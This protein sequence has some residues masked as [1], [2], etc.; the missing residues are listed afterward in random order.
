M[1][2]KFTLFLLFLLWFSA[3]RVSAQCPTAPPDVTIACGSSHLLNAQS[4]NVAYNVTAT[5]C[6]PVAITGTN[7]FPT[8][9]DDCVTGQ[10]PIGFNFDFYGNNYTTAVI[11]SNGLLG[12][13]AFTYTG[14][15]PFPIPAAGTPNNYIAGFHAD[16]DIRFGGTITYQTVGTAPNRRFVVSYNNVVPYSFGTGAGIGTASFQ[17]ILNENGSF[18]VVVSQLSANWNATTSGAL[19]TSGAENNDGTL[20][21]P[22]PGRNNTDWPGIVPA[23]QDCH[24]FSRI[25]CS[26]VRWEVAGVSVSTSSSY[27][28]SPAATTTYTAVWNCIG[29]GAPP[30][31]TDNVTVTV[32]PNLLTGTGATICQGAPSVALT[33]NNACGGAPISQGA[34]FNAGE[35]TVSDP[36]WNRNS[37]GTT[38]GA[39]AGTNQYYDVFAFTVST[40]GS[41]TFDGCF[42]TIDGHASLYQNAFDGSSPCAV[43]SNFIVALVPGVVYYIVSTTFGSGSTGAYSWTFS[44]PAGATISSGLGGVEWYTAASG[45]TPIGTGTNFNPVGVAGSGLANTNTAGTTTYYAACASTPNCRIALN[46]VISAAPSIS[47]ISSNT[48]ACSGASVNLS[49]TSAGNTIRWYNAPTGGTLLGTS[50]SGANFVVSPLTTTTYYAEAYDGSCATLTR[51]AVTVTVSAPPYDNFCNAAPVFVG[52]NG[53]FSNTCATVEGG[54]IGGSCFTATNAVTNSIWTA[55]T[56]AVTAPYAI[57]ITQGTDNTFAATGGFFDSELAIFT[58]SATCPAAPSLTQLACNDNGATAIEPVFSAIA[59]VNLTAGVT[60][61]IQIDGKAY[62]DAGNA[63]LGASN[64][65]DIILFI[66]QLDPLPVE[67]K[68]FEGQAE[69]AHNL[70]LWETA[71]EKDIAHFV[72]EASTDGIAFEALGKVAPHQRPSEYKFVHQNPEHLTYY[73]LMEVSLAGEKSYSKTLLLKREGVENKVGLLAAYPNPTKN[74][75]NLRLYTQEAELMQF[76]LTDM[77]GVVVL[78]SSLQT[79]ARQTTE[80]EFSLQNLK[81]GVYMLILTGKNGKEVIK[82]VKE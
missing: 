79:A 50:A 74:N 12:F 64:A 22:V 28:V 38:C 20:A 14:Y 51:S 62:F 65:D 76:Q 61:Y 82:I 30:T 52:S 21:F 36:T 13:G 57:S 69:K 40:A 53:T 9:C 66:E 72:V 15:T 63:F 43:P 42:P 54:E 7:A 41:Y 60:Y 49:A 34:V 55:F 70:L 6:T 5:S 71:M 11:Q 67:W 16:I 29:G 46:Y 26:F 10:I 3:E 37:G 1:N 17:I 32:S 80:T 23:N 47:A 33:T 4:M 19:A 59:S 2:N 39:S 77:R 58:N 27:S 35:L 31:C 56:P 24:L 18:N 73:R 75:L 45:G 25:E 8:A 44:G 78:T 81:A 68:R 48:T